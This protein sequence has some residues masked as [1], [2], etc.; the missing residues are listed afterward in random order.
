MKLFF[1][2]DNEYLVDDD[3]DEAI[4]VD[5]GEMLFQFMGI[6]YTEISAALYVDGKR[7]SVLNE[8]FEMYIEKPYILF[9]ITTELEKIFSDNN[10]DYDKEGIFY[11][12][13]ET[14]KGQTDF[15]DENTRLKYLKLNNHNIDKIALFFMML[16]QSREILVEA[17]QFC[18]GANYQNEMSNVRIKRYSNSRRFSI[19][20]MLNESDNGDFLKSSLEKLINKLAGYYE[21]L[22]QINTDFEIA[23]VCNGD[24]GKIVN[25]LAVS[26]K[27]LKQILSGSE[28]VFPYGD[29]LVNDAEL[30]EIYDVDNFFNIMYLEII[31]LINNNL[32]TKI[33]E[34]CNKIFIPKNITAE[35]CDRV[36]KNGRTCKDIGPAMKYQEK[37]AEDLVMQ[38]Y[39][40]ERAKRYMR[41]KRNPEKFDKDG[42]ATWLRYAEQ[43]K[44]EVKAGRIDFDEYEKLLSK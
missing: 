7:E 31:N 18:A 43:L 16:D 22:P 21:E 32:K 33:C 8:F 24:V 1:Y 44:V 28:F 42:L 11:E 12:V 2:D 35:Y 37:I 13:F 34:N 17:L 19:Y 25:E 5:Y 41:N 29:E 4:V 23:F 38:T 36:I 40:K 27:K 9:F 3:T 39:N 15:L 26:E 10:F 6:K 30:I 20:N 14:F